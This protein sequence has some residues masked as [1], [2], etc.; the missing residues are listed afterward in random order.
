MT[1]QQLR[2]SMR[3]STQTVS[4]QCTGCTRHHRQLSDLIDVEGAG[5][6]VGLGGAGGGHHQLVPT[7]KRHSGHAA[8]PL[9]L[10]PQLAISGT[11]AVNDGLH[12]THT[13]QS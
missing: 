11:E 9:A 13:S 3:Y 7:H 12:H 5:V 6:Q 4:R 2:Y 10:L 8:L 1:R